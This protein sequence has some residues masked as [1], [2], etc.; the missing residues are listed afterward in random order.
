M[1]TG[2]RGIGQGEKKDFKYIYADAF[3]AFPTVGLYIQRLR[4]LRRIL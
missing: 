4:G 1:T 3:G 2:E